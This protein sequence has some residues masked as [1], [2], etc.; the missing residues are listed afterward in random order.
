[1]S[2]LDVRKTYKLYIDGEFPRSESGRCYPALDSDG[3]VLAR[4][5]LG[6]RKDLRDAVRRPRRPGQWAERSGYNR[7]QVLYRIAEM[8]EDRKATFVEQWTDSG[9]TGEEARAEVAAS[10]R[11]D[12][13][14]RR[15]GRQVRP[16][17]RQP[18]SGR[19]AI[20]QHLRTRSDRC[21]RGDR[22]RGACTP[23]LVSR[24]AP[25]MVPGNTA[26]VL[27]SE[28]QPMP[29]ITFHRGTRQLR[30]PGRGGQHVDRAAR[31]S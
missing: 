14:V 2:R 21:R 24:L 18:Q 29:A 16:D 12:G 17:L 6:S 25:V 27:A 15:M 3:E 1:M 9:S 5:A 7:G 28:T 10:D 8:L 19:R 22:P 20:L 11:S 26:V 4:V 23:R 31:P 13:L 30:R